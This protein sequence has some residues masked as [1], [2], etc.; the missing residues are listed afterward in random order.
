MRVPAKAF[1]GSCNEYATSTVNLYSVLYDPLRYRSRAGTIRAH[2][3]PRHWHPS[4]SMLGCQNFTGTCDAVPEHAQTGRMR[5]Y[6]GGAHS[7]AKLT[8]TM[9]AKNTR[10]SR[11]RLYRNRALQPVPLRTAACNVAKN[12]VQT[13]M[14]LLGFRIQLCRCCGL[15]GT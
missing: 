8:S 13:R 11:P 4:S 7:R 1:P 12:P 2:P 3:H 9:T 14:L 10:C 5:D 6:E 15:Y